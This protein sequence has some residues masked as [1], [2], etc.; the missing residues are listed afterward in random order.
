MSAV[1]EE[2]FGISIMMA[3]YNAEREHLLEAINSVTAQ[4]MDPDKY[5]ILLVNDGSSKPET[6][7]TIAEIG[8][9]P[10]IYPNVRIFHQENKGQSAARNKAIRHANFEFLTGL[11]S[12]D[13]LNTDPK[14]MKRHG[15]YYMRGIEQ[16]KKDE[17]LAFVYCPYRSLSS[18]NHLSQSAPRPHSMENLLTKGISVFAITR[19][20]DVIAAGGFSE[21]LD[22]VEDWAM[23]I[24][25]MNER[26]SKGKGLGALKYAEPYYDYRQHDHG[27][28]VNN[29]ERDYPALFSYLVTKNPQI[30]KHFYGDIAPREMAERLMHDHFM[31][32]ASQMKWYLQTAFM[33]P[34][35]T[36]KHGAPN[37]LRNRWRRFAEKIGM[38]QK[39]PPDANDAASP[40]SFSQGFDRFFDKAGQPL[41]FKSIRAEVLPQRIAAAE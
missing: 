39:L 27:Q 11:D 29:R 6:L 22:C 35:W 12:D 17:V 38:R 21:N 13:R 36:L 34:A 40:R 16:L 15:G 14:I 8:L 9:R 23:M 1:R 33:H 24:S 32:K 37:F 28:N 18:D 41:D 3:C 4:G 5:E 10:D 7:S 30:Y 31:I 25:L 2:K 26:V 20:Q 19:R